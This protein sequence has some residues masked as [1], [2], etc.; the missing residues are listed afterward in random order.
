MVLQVS[1]SAAERSQSRSLVVV[2]IGIA[3]AEEQVGALSHLVINTEVA[4]VAIV[5]ERRVDK[6]VVLEAGEVREWKRVDKRARYR[7]NRTGGDH[8][9]GERNAPRACEWR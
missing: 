6:Q 4:A 2:V 8:V 3:P 9:S 7:R 1:R 5:A